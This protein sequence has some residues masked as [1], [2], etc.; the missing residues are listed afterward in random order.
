MF[1]ALDKLIN[2]GVSKVIVA[3]PERSIGSSFAYTDLMS[4]GFYANW[5]PNDK[6]NLCTPGIDNSKSKVDAF[7]EFMKSDEKDFDLYTRYIALCL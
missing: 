6:Y 4:H 2:Q 1:I 7:V 3:V 5:E